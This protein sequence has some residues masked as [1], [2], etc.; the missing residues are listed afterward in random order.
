[1]NIQTA[2]RTTLAGLCMVPVTG[3]LAQDVDSGG[4]TIAEVVVSSTRR[5][6]EVQDVPISI[7]AVGGEAAES[8]GLENLDE[9]ASIVEQIMAR[10]KAGEIDASWKE[11]A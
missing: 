8:L 3:A 10:L 2:V 9:L 5:D 11:D 6:M 4:D 7:T 1:M